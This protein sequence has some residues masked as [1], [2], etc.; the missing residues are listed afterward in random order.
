MINNTPILDLKD[1]I[2]N[3][4]E[5]IFS[6]EVLFHRKNNN[7]YKNYVKC[8]SLFMLLSGM[9]IFS[10]YVGYIYSKDNNNSSNSI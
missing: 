10:F 1:P 3:D 5:D 7:K 4:S 2:I 9:N 6:P 8:C